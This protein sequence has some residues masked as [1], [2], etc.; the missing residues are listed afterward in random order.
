MQNNQYETLS[1]A[2]NALTQA[3]FTAQFSLDGHKVYTPDHKNHYAAKEMKL[4]CFH[5]FEGQTNPADMSIVYALEAPDG[6]KGTL[7][8]AFG[9]DGDL[10]GQ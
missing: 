6:S 9:V 7:V 8:G 4:H 10:F 2:V 3:G 5:R 1:E